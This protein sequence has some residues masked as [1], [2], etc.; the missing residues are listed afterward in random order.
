MEE[1]ARRAAIAAKR[2]A[3]EAAIAATRA[4]QEDVCN[5]ALVVAERPHHLGIHRASRGRAAEAKTPASLAAHEEVGRLA[6]A[7]PE[8]YWWWITDESLDTIG[9]ELESK[10]YCVLDNFLGKKGVAT[11]RKEVSKIHSS[12]HLEISRLAGGRSGKNTTY[13]HTA[14]RGDHVG[15]FDG[16]EPKLWPQGSLPRYFQKVDTLIAQLGSRVPQLANIAHRS[17]AMVACYPGGGARYVRHCDNSCDTG[18]GDRCN[19][20]RLTAI[21]YLNEGW[22]VLHGGELRLY[23]PFAPKDKPPLCDVAP[24]CDRLVLFYA[25]Y[26]VPHEV[27]AAHCERLAVTCWY[28]D[29]AEHAAAK[30]RGAAAEQ[31]NVQEQEAIQQEIKRFEERFGSEGLSRHGDVYN[32]DPEDLYERV[33]RA[34]VVL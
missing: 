8:S 1:D 30:K 18:R 19:G 6:G 11:L 15:W 2:A 32:N 5:L 7:D 29:G 14:V 13:S 27:L 3:I 16:E 22:S 34:V 25:D 10:N 21:I 26:R 33:S 9:K 12:G 28:F 4:K 17:K 31:I 24:L 23:A 20:R